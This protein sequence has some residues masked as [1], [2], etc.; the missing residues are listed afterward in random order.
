MQF[1]VGWISSHHRN[2]PRKR[3]SQF[4]AK[5]LKPIHRPPPAERAKRN[6]SGALTLSYSVPTIS[7]PCGSCAETIS[8]A[9]P[10]PVLKN[11]R[12]FS[13]SKTAQTS[14]LGFKSLPRS[15]KDAWP[16]NRG[17]HSAQHRHPSPST[18]AVHMRTFKFS[19]VFV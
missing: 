4:Q 15:R 18:Y 16:R 9:C 13:T 10:E 19:T 2:A 5:V 3:P 8:Y 6:A 7:D 1:A 14:S 17:R 12:R 11:D